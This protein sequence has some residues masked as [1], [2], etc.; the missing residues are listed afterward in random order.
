MVLP[1]KIDEVCSIT[2]GASNQPE[3]TRR[4]SRK[5]LGM[6]W[7]WFRICS[8]MC[9]LL[10]LPVVLFAFACSH[11][12]APILD[13]M[14]APLPPPPT[15]D[16]N[17]S[18][19]EIFSPVFD[20]MILR[21]ASAA[22]VE[23]LRA[24]KELELDV[25]AIRTNIVNFR[26]KADYSHNFNALGVS[27]TQAF[28]AKHR[29][30]LA[31]CARKTGVEPEVIAAI[32]WVETKFGK[33]TG[34]KHVASVYLS[35]AL[36]EEPYF[37]ASNKQALRELFEGDPGDLAALDRRIEE[38]SKSKSEWA[39]EQLLALE[40]AQRL[41]KP[42]VDKLRG[43]WAG[44]FGLGQFIPSSYVKHAIDA[45][46]DGKVDPIDLRDGACSIGNFLK[47]HGWAASM[48]SRRQAVFHYNRSQDYVT[49][50]LT[51]AERSGLRPP[52]N[53]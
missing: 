14:P 22:F 15:F 9:R 24:S 36:A 2:S 28:L 51:L 10:V 49:A 53:P 38:R 11:A 19:V 12:E 8:S 32:L 48:E 21:G 7:D 17:R 25:G 39:I 3:E 35:L 31:N 27:R 46:G 47:N 44:A 45:S 16:L 50:V 30:V 52:L 4:K 41:L 26:M 42:R 5:S 1:P 40:Q 20:R 37:V 43:S 34:K 18:A 23:R 13:E 6:P 29:R 33:T